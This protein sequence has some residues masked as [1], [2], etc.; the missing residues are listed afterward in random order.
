MSRAW[1]FVGN[2]A[3]CLCSLS[4]VQISLLL[5]KLAMQWTLMVQL[6]VFSLRCFPS[7]VHAAGAWWELDTPSG[8]G[9]ERQAAEPEQPRSTNGAL[10]S[11]SRSSSSSP[12]ASCGISNRAVVAAQ[13]GD[14]ELQDVKFSYPTRPQALVLKDLTLTLPRGKVTA[15]VGRS[16]SGKST[17]AALLERLYTVDAG[18]VTCNGVSITDF[19][20][21]EWVEAVTAVSQEPVLWSASIR[22][23]IAYG[24]RTASSMEEIVAAAKAAHA[25]EFVQALPEGY[26]TRVSSK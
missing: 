15:L 3:L 5:V 9:S 1:R 13:Q 21:A 7:P 4:T 19:S 24:R 26:D 11:P 18:R 22:D 23:N 6:A 2:V 16:G 12:K 20:R 8:A 10:A 25:H 14:I 17:V